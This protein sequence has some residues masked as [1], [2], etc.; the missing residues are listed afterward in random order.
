MKVR[1]LLVGALLG[2]SSS[3]FAAPAHACMGEVCD[4]I[5]FVCAKVS[6][7]ASCVG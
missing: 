1:I 3:L 6:K 5:N 2:I 7:G 4:A